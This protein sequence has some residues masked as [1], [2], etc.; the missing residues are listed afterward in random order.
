[1][2][3]LP[4]W[5]MKYVHKSK[6]HAV[7]IVE[8][9]SHGEVCTIPYVYELPTMGKSDGMRAAELITAAPELLENAEKALALLEAI[10][11]EYGAR[12]DGTE[13]ETTATRQALNAAIM[14]AKGE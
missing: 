9:G 4:K 1:M 7:K 11:C 6:I 3:T 2:E 12:L 13:L 5:I 8:W 14:K 10:A